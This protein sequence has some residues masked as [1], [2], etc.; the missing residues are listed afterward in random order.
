VYT[1][2]EPDIC[3]GETFKET[4]LEPSCECC[5]SDDHAMLAKSTDPQHRTGFK[6]TCPV[7]TYIRLDKNYPRYPINLDFYACPTK[8]AEIHHYMNDERLTTALENYRMMSAARVDY[9]YSRNF[10]NEVLRLCADYQRSLNFKRTR[11]NEDEDEFSD[12][13]QVEEDGKGDDLSLDK[14]E[15]PSQQ[16]MGEREG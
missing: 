4:F 16:K 11:L 10:V 6:Y 2:V 14:E 1:Q 9:S 7:A 5:G 3:K 15:E 13:D 12:L 8:F